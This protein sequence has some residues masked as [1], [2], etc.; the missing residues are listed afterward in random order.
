LTKRVPNT[1]FKSALL[2]LLADLHP[3]LDDFDPAVHD[4]LLKLGAEFQELS[5]L[6]FAAK[7]HRV[8]YSRGVVPASFKD[9]NF[10]GSR[11]ML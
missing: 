7:A 5:I 4:V 2:L 10:P 9:D 6:L 11:K 8:F 3:V 1:S